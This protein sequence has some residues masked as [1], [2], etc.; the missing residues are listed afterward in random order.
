MDMTKAAKV[1]IWRFVDKNGVFLLNL[2]EYPPACLVHRQRKEACRWNS[3]KLILV[4]RYLC[5]CYLIL[6]ILINDL[7][8]S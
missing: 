4:L 5:S 1:L 7:N 3:I 2:F 8:L 6:Q